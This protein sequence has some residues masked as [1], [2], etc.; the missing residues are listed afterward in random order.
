M[1]WVGMHVYICFGL[2]CL[3][4]I[5]LERLYAERS[6]SLALYIVNTLIYLIK[7]ID[8]VRQSMGA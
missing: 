5:R 1:F 8:Q 3:C 6:M 2:D 7:Y 4:D